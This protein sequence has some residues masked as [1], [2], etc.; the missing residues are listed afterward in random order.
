MLTLYS[1]NNH[2]SFL[3]ENHEKIF[4]NLS[5]FMH[6][7]YPHKNEQDL[8]DLRT[9]TLIFR[10]LT[11][12]PVNLKFILGTP[13]FQTFVAMFNSG[14]DHEC[15]KNIIDIMN[16]LV[17]VGWDCAQILREINEAILDDKLEDVEGGVELL[18]GLI[19]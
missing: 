8:E 12:N 14:Y 19:D 6:G 7:I 3:F 16:G 15:S 13:I 10:N 11:M 5:N 18:R 9:V 17:K 1:V 4:T 2:P